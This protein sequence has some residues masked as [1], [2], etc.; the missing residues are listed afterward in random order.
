MPASK[1]FGCATQ[2]VVA[3]DVGR[4]FGMEAVKAVL[5]AVCLQILAAS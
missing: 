1:V 4:E 5:T 3:L 2:R